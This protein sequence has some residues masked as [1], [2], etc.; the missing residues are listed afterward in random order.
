MAEL[1]GIREIVSHYP[2]HYVLLDRCRF[3]E[4]H[5]LTHGQIVRSSEDCDEVYDALREHPNSV[6]IFTGQV[7]GEEEGAFLDRGRVR[8]L[9]GVE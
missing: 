3:D 1:L 8:S 4:V 6:I 7:T 9:C 2:R 5:E